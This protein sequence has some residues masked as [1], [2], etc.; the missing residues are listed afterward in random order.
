[1]VHPARDDTNDICAI[2]R[3]MSDIKSALKSINVSTLTYQEWVNV[4]MAIKAEGLPCSI[5][6]EWSRGDKRYKAGECERKWGSFQGSMNPVTAATIF[7]MARENGWRPEMSGEAMNWNDEISD[8]GQGFHTQA[9]EQRPV[10]ELITYLD[11]LFKASDI[12]GYCT[13]DVWQDSDGSWSRE[14]EYSTERRRI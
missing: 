9:A 6:D 5:W 1:M 3:N 14:E 7:Q 4:G 13:N 2:R 11:V 8:D 12:V 10:D